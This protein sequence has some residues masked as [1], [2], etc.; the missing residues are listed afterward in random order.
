MNMK[1]SV[2]V[3]PQAKE[4][5]IEKSGEGKYI[6]WVKAKAIEGKANRAVVE[7]LSDYFNV[8]KSDISL[9]KGD[10]VRDKIFELILP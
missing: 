9:L 4:N 10:R 7:I 5:R 8:S 2:R 1:I 3:K 6:I